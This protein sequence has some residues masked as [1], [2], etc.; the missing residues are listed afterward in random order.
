MQQY[1]SRTNADHITEIFPT[2][3]KLVTAKLNVLFQY[4]KIPQKK[5]YT[6][7]CNRRITLSITQTEHLSLFRQTISVTK[8]VKE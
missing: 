2:L 7:K 8:C 5:I 6:N 4:D 3:Q 1:W